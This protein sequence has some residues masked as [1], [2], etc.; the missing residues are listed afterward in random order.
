MFVSYARGDRAPVRAIV[1]ALT[2][3]GY[4]VWWDHDIAGGA[5]FSRELATA[6][7]SAEVLVVAWSR[8]PVGSA[9]GREECAGGRRRGGAVPGSQRQ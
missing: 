9:G 4:S 2:A 8:A 7:K 6:L 5:A 1:S 3:R